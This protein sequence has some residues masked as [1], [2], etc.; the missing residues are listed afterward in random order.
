MAVPDRHRRPSRTAL[1][2]L[3]HVAYRSGYVGDAAAITALAHDAGT[4]VLLAL[5]H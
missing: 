1:V 3:S 4:L 2:L 5:F